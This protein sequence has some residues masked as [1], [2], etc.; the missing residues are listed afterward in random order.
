MAGQVGLLT[1]GFFLWSEGVPDSA[2]A[3]A[4]GLVACGVLVTVLLVRE[5]DPVTWRAASEAEA[6]VESHGSLRLT[7]T[8]T[9]YR[10]AVLLCLVVF[11]YWS[12]VN[13]VMPLV[14][15]YTRDILGATVGEAQLLPAMLLLS[16]TL[17]AVPIGMFGTRYGKRRTIAAGYAI[18]G[19]AALAGLVIT[20]QE[21]GAVV[22]LLAGSATPRYGADHPTDGRP[23]AAPAPG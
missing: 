14:S 1:L 21:Q 4:G 2:F 8:F 23:G 3:L 13:A 11:F 19:V 6:P 7:T 9:R 17:T 22:F 15:V 5:P 16:T 20:H 12:G 18:M 10:G